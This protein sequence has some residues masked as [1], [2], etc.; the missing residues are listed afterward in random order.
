M[1]KRT[2]AMSIALA[3][4]LAV[5]PAALT[6]CSGDHYSEI[7]FA[8]QD[9]SYVVTSQGGSA[10]SYGNYVYFINGTRGY[11]DTNGNA[12][13]WDNVVKGA[14]Y[15]AEYNGEKVMVDG[16][17]RF[18]RAE[19]DDKGMEFK[20]SVGRDYLDTKDVNVVDTIKV[21]PKTIGTE[22]YSD[23]GIFI[24]DNAVYFASPNN[25][26]SSSGTV[27]TTRT[28]FFMMPL[29][30]GEPT[31]LYTTSEG[32]NTS[33][34]AYAFYKYGG[35]V[36]LVVNEGGNIVSVKI[37]A[38]K[39][40]ADD[41]VTFQVNATSVYFPVRDTYYNGISTNTPE[42]FIYY[43]RAVTDNDREKNGTVIEAMR[44]NGSEN[45]VVS[46]NGQTETIEA[47]R[48]G[49]FFYRTTKVNNTVIAYTNLHD[50]LM[51]YSA[52]YRNEQ[53]AREENDKIKQIKGT[54]ENM[55]GVASLTATYAFRS[56]EL[57][58]TVYFVGVTSSGMS[59]YQSSGVNISSGV[60][61]G[62]TVGDVDVLKYK[63]CS[64]TGTPLFIK[65]NYLYYSGSS[66]DYYRVP[67]F[68]NMEGFGEAEK[69]ASDTKSGSLSCD[70]VDGYF[71][72]YAEVDQWANGYTFFYNV[73]GVKGWD[74][75]FVGARASG[76]IPTADQIK[77]AKGET[78]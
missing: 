48:D 26:K 32:V 27:Q 9:T 44:P 66:N 67:L 75:Q 12:N 71:T 17:N 77:E 16:L 21:A 3:S 41:P 68:D 64:E 78:D 20:Y 34:S 65:N 70:Y 45:F 60:S 22:G 28:D 46:M 42:D 36:Y 39:Q 49:I 74:P 8:A 47:V 33:S 24:Y 56:D 1:K 51:E 72:Y 52:S 14:L 13:V 25:E 55:N 63:I 10:V 7:K 43:V 19:P 31:K 6:G 38:S 11:D 35:S 61:Q 29:N 58:N 54:F 69:L 18:K 57:S 5:S 62:Q 53:N 15:R 2:V 76:D 50:M 59:L 73:D 30:G 4:V 37:N 23:G 40:K